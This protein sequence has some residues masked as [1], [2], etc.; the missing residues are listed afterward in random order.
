MLVIDEG[1]C[2]LRLRYEG[3]VRYVSR[4]LPLR[5][6]LAPLAE[7]LSALEPTGLDWVS[8]GVGSLVT[9]MRPVSQVSGLDPEVVKR[10]IVDYLKT[11]PGVWD[12]FRHGGAL[13]PLGERRTAE[14]NRAGGV[15]GLAIVRLVGHTGQTNSW[16]VPTL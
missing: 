6:D 16:R 1:R 2:E 15:L 8:D 10:A 14:Q 12:P 5:P 7:E 11:A 3:W 9:R 13:V 4:R